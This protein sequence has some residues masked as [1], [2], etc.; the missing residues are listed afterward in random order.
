MNTDKLT[1]FKSVYRYGVRKIKSLWLPYFLYMAIF[2]VLHNTF[3]DLN[4]YT[5]N[6]LYLEE[7]TGRYAVL[8]NYRSTGETVKAVIDSGLFQGNAQIGGALWFFYALFLL[9]IGYAVIEFI[10]RKIIKNYKWIRVSQGIVSILF[11]FVGY[12]LHLEGKSVC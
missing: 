5:D 11:L 8:T 10:L 7:Y 4:V 12:Y 6:P 1:D 9:S 3:I 2:S